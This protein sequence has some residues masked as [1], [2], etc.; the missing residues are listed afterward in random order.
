LGAGADGDYLDGD[1]QGEEN[2]VHA[3]KIRH[4]SLSF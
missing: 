1:Q 3:T 4:P 2:P